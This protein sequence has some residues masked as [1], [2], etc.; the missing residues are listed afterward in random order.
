MKSINESYR[1]YIKIIRKLTPEKKLK[2][3]VLHREKKYRW[4]ILNDLI[5]KI[6]KRC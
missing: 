1:E 6:D 4:Q 2:D 5:N 3:N